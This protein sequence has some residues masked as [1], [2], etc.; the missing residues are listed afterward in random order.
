MVVFEREIT[1]GNCR[2]QD[3]KIF[4]CKARDLPFDV[5]YAEALH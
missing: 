5:S 1:T 3:K 4:L 2:K